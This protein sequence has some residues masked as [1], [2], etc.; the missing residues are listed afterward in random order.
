MEHKKNPEEVNLPTDETQK[1][2]E[3][4][5]NKLDMGSDILQG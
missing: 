1:A 5:E 4:Q 3:T 2:N